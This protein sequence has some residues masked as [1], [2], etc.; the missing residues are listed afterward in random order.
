M[1][2]WDFISKESQE[3]PP[4]CPWKDRH[5]H[6]LRGWTG[7]SWTQRNT[8]DLWEGV[9]VNKEMKFLKNILSLG[10]L[11]H[12]SK[13]NHF[14]PK[15]FLLFVLIFLCVYPC[16]HKLVSGKKV[17]ALLELGMELG[18]SERA[19]PSHTYYPAKMSP[20]QT[21]DSPGT[22]VCDLSLCDGT[23]FSV[24]HQNS[25]IPSHFWLLQ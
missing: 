6:S 20:A 12:F 3:L 14:N 9:F 18:S 13:T 11:P 8:A 4:C 19:A 7:A 15:P 23:Q 1:A 17:S 16:A 24:W 5:R 10:N 21:R 22:P 2:P 25:S